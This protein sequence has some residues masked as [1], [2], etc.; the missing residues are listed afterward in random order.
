[1]DKLANRGARFNAFHTVAFGKE[2][3]TGLG[4]VL[5]WPTSRG[6]EYFFGFLGTETDQFHPKL[7]RNTVALEDAHLP[8]GEML[9]K[10]LAEE[11]KGAERQAVPVL[12]RSRELLVRQRTMLISAIRG[13]RGEFGRSRPQV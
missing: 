4:A 8:N 11:T 7:Y 10:R 5:R 2:Q 9:D 13:H 3:H 12:H 1:M 6:F